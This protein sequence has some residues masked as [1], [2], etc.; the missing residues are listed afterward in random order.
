MEPNERIQD[1][2]EKLRQ[3]RDE[4]RL[5]MHLAKADARD[6]WEELEGKWESLKDRLKAAGG[7]ASE[8]S[9][10]IGGALRGLASEIKKGYERIRNQL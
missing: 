4:L 9:E 1:A 8:A 10:D 6:E 2:V 5:K 7:E 3:Q